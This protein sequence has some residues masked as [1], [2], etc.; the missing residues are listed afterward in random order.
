MALPKPLPPKDDPN[1][2][3]RQQI[4]QYLNFTA[5]RPSKPRD[6]ELAISILMQIQKQWGV[7]PE[8]AAGYMTDWWRFPG[9][10]GALFR[11]LSK[12]AFNRLHPEQA[13]PAVSVPAPAVK[14]AGDSHLVMTIKNRMRSWSNAFALGYSW[15]LTGT[16]PYIDPRMIGDSGNQ[17]DTGLRAG[18]QAGFTAKHKGGPV[19]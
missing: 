14:D 4:I 3:Q 17:F 9:F 11:S 10:D 15:G 12:T 7:D 18:F 2:P 8:T 6:T 5:G 16:E 19:K 1:N 13:P